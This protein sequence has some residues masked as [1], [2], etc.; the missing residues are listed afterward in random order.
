MMSVVPRMTRTSPSRSAPAT[1]CSP[2][3]SME[4]APRTA[5]PPAR[6]LLTLPTGAPLTLTGG[7]W[8]GR[9]PQSAMAASSHM[10]PSKSG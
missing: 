3:A 1:I 8:S 7:N 9:A 5:S 10:F 4:L 2:M 6:F